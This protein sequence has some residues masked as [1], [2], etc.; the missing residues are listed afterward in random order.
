M[1]SLYVNLSI[2]TLTCAFGWTIIAYE[3]Y[4]RQ[5]AWPVGNLFAG[6][7]SWVQGVAYIAII[8]AAI[9]SFIVTSWWGPILVIVVANLLVRIQF[10]IFKSKSPIL[11]TVGVFIGITLTIFHVL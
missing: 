6:N 3:G 2:L 5:R 11:A 7:F 1:D 9:I 8:G 4:A 10:S